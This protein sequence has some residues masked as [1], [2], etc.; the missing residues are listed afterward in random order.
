MV[1][2]NFEQKRPMGNPS[3]RESLPQNDQNP[4]DNWVNQSRSIIEAI[5]QSPQ[6]EETDPGTRF[7]EDLAK[8]LDRSVMNS[9]LELAQ[10]LDDLT[11]DL[12]IH[13]FLTFGDMI[14]MARDTSVHQL[15]TL[16]SQFS[17][18]VQSLPLPT[19]N[20][21]LVQKRNALVEAF[22]YRSKQLLGE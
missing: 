18:Q 19:D 21:V 12:H 9:P 15:G 22:E 17:K 14:V 7:S 10:L 5:D 11:N 8:L 6:L 16:F 3:K 20:P 4:I 13:D 1:F 2:G